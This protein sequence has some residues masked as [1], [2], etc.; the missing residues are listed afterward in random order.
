MKKIDPRNKTCIYLDQFVVSNLV[1]HPNDTWKE[2]RSMLEINY[3]KN[4][5]YCPL[6][7]QHVLETAKKEINN[8]VIHDEYFRKLS[9]NYVFKNEIFLTSQLISSLIRGNR[10][11]IN[12]YLETSPFQS[13]NDCYSQINDV[14]KVFN[15]SINYHVL[16][17]NAIRKITNGKIEK[18]IEN[19]FIE[20]IKN[21]EV[22]NFIERLEFC[23]K[24]KQIYI[25]P[26]NYGTHECPNW[27]DQ[28]LFQLYHRH[29]FKE[30]N[31]KQFLNELK[32]NGFNRIATLN[33][34][35]SLGAYLTVKHK[36]ENVSD[37]I[38]IMRISNGLSASDIFFT[39][40]KRKFE[41]IELGLDK[42]YNTKIYCGVEKDLLDFNCYLQDLK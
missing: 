10:H 30:N 29:S 4:L 22:E 15:E 7:H 26:D 35:F 40:K 33:I 38:D 13:F 41:I 23:I 12:T 8:A 6:S 19:K 24:E 25:R 31:F 1:D 5:L 16:S 36:Q 27:I 11:T 42:L 2:I 18:K 28:L 14:N 20:V 34:R 9:D 39:D 17:Q 32:I 37:H 3:S 21:N